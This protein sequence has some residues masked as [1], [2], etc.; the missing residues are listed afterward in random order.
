MATAVKGR[1]HPGVDDALDERVTEQIRAQ[2]Q[3][4]RIVVRA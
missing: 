1:G 4:I 2:T 3:H